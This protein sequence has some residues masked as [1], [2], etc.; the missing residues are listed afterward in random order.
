[1][2][3][4][5]AWKGGA[6]ARL[7]GAPTASRTCAS[8]RRFVIRLPRRVRGKR[9]A[10][11]RVRVDGRPVSVQR[12]GGRLVAFVDLTGK[13]KGAYRVAVTTVTRGGKHH[14]AVRRFRTCERRR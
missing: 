11:G 6:V 3:R 12:V 7:G 14:T 4:A 10:R 13:R 1:M 8:R 5:L 9:V 2:L